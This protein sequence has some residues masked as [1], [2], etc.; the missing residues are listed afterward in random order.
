[1]NNKLWKTTVVLTIF[2]TDLIIQ[3]QTKSALVRNKRNHLL[4]SF[5]IFKLWLKQKFRDIKNNESIVVA[6]IS[7]AVLTVR[8]E[9]PSPKPGYRSIQRQTTE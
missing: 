3:G 4:H 8:P 6:A 7:S 1:M 2:L 5:A 9:G